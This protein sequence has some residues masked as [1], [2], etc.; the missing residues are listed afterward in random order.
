VG[1]SIYGNRLTAAQREQL[2]R[3]AGESALSPQRQMAL[4]NI[5]YGGCYG[6]Q[7]EAM[8]GATAA[9]GLSRSPFMTIT[10]LTVKN[11]TWT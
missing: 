10:V 5:V 8:A 7:L 4:A 9:E 1:L 6:N 11:L 2:G 3:K